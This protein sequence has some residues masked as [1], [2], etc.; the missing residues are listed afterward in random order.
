MA[1]GFL[2]SVARSMRTRVWARSPAT[3]DS[4]L[5]PALPRT[6]HRD[7]RGPLTSEP[8]GSRLRATRTSADER[9]RR[10]RVG[11]RPPVSATSGAGAERAD[12]RP[13]PEGRLGRY[14]F[15]SAHLTA[16]I[17]IAEEPAAV[18]AR[19]RGPPRARTGPMV[20]CGLHRRHRSEPQSVPG[21]TCR[22]SPPPGSQIWPPMRFA[23]RPSS[24]SA[25]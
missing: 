20:G 11:C 8:R 9:V 22:T 17:A 10:V 12:G 5:S 6:W 15:A 25:S 1:S 24:R 16:Q 23:V 19:T 7:C 4:L 13:P 21:P 3:C 2:C 18:S 14:G